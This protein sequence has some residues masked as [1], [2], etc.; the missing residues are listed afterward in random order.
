[1]FLKIQIP[2]ETFFSTESVVLR[3]IMFSPIKSPDINIF[4]RTEFFGLKLKDLF[5]GFWWDELRQPISY[6]INKTQILAYDSFLLRL[7]K[8]EFS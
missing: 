6:L 7:Y 3:F 5:S 1:M 2:F 4:D 8:Y